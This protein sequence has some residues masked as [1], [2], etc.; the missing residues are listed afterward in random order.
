[1]KLLISFIKNYNFYKKIIIGVN[2]LNQLKQIIK[3]FE[4]KNNCNKNQF[5]KYK[6]SDQFNRSTKLEN[7][8]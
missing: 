7:L 6:T 1:M 3:F 2:S 8:I 4:Q 5:L